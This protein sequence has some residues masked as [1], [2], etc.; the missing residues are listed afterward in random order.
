MSSSGFQEPFNVTQNAGVLPDVSYL[1]EVEGVRKAFQG[2]A[3]DLPWRRSILRTG[4]D[5]WNVLPVI[6][7]APDRTLKMLVD[8]TNATPDKKQ[9][10]IIPFAIHQR[11]YLSWC[12]FR[13][14]TRDA[15]IG[16]KI[17]YITNTIHNR[18][19]QV[20]NHHQTAARNKRQNSESGT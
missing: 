18:H 13:A 19:V 11:E 20:P 15:T 1:L 3:P 6:V 17:P 2:V 16:E 10:S 5:P 12:P 9:S 7:L 14:Y 4:R 8:I